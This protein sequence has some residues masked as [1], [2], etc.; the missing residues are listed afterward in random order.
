MSGA[1]CRTRKVS[2]TAGVFEC[3]TERSQA[4][5]DARC[6]CA[7][8]QMPVDPLR[9]GG[10]TGHGG[11]EQ[12]VVQLSPQK[13]GR[14]VHIG[15]GDL[16]QGVVDES[17]AFQAGGDPRKAHI[18]LQVDAQVFRFALFEHP[19][20]VTSDPPGC[21]TRQVVL[22]I[23]PGVVQNVKRIDSAVQTW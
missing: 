7:F 6:L 22:G 14:Q 21:S 16:G 11:N 10:A 9:L 3:G 18:L 19:V 8:G 13:T 2:N 1:R 4:H 12:W 23:L 17:V 20:P 5:G 15:E